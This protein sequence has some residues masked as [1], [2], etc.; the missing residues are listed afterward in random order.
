MDKDHIAASRT[1]E[2]A[3]DDFAIA[4]FARDTGRD[5]EYKQ[6]LKQSENWKNA[7]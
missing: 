5:D 6:F 7:A 2:Y 1:L 3:S 4:Q